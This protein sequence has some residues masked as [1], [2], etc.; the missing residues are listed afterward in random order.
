MPG[1]KTQCQ[2]VCSRCYRPK[3]RT[4]DPLKMT[5][6]ASKS[7]IHWLVVFATLCALGAWIIP[8][9]HRAADETLTYFPAKLSVLK[10]K[11]RAIHISGVDFQSDLIRERTQVLARQMV[12]VCKQRSDD[13]IF[14]FQFGVVGK[15]R[16]REDHIFS[17]C[18]NSTTPT[19]V[20]ANA[21]VIG[22]SED[23]ILCAEDHGGMMREVRRHSGVSI[24]AID[25]LTWEPM[26]YDVDDVK[27]ACVVQHAI[28][29]LE[30]TW[31]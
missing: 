31:V 13:V 7:K 2:Q 25:I 10:R 16:R 20:F 4:D 15:G 27:E 18:G 14:A 26:E 23:F 12:Y 6:R 29:V 30:S 28:D 3:V 21:V 1:Q 9:V 5:P 24:K 22:S 17:L 8:E 11:P 19:R